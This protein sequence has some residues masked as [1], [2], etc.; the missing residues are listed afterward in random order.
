MHTL[1]L[2]INVTTVIN[3]AVDHRRGLKRPRHICLGW[4]KTIAVA[5]SSFWRDA[6]FRNGRINFLRYKNASWSFFKVVECTFVFLI[7]VRKYHEWT[8]SERECAV[9]LIT[10]LCI[11]A[12]SR[13]TSE[14]VATP[15]PALDTKPSYDI[16]YR[17][18]CATY[19]LLDWFFP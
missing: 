12:L 3:I 18:H 15:T 9:L 10:G 16:S 17:V 2:I 8:V 7:I 5:I 14:P 1:V 11:S 13:P 4:A 6:M 19:T